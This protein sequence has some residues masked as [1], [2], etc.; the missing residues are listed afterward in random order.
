M[1]IG[2]IIW[3]LIGVLT[4]FDLILCSIYS[5]LRRRHDQQKTKLKNRISD[6]KEEAMKDKQLL[7]KFARRIDNWLYGLC[8]YTSIWVG[9]VPSYTFRR[10]IFRYVF[11]MQINRHAIIHGGCEIRSPWNIKIGNSVIGVGVILDGR[12][13]IEIEDDV[14]L[15]SGVWIWTEQHD[16]EDPYFRCLDK[17]GM[18]VIRKH[19]WIGN[20]VI[21]L[22]RVTIEEGDV[23]AAGAVV[24]KNC[25]PFT[26]YGGVPAKE[27][28]KRNQD[29]RYTD[30]TAGIWPF[31]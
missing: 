19:A 18:V 12:N 21:I 6:V 8:R 10:W 30:V 20:R 7:K 16:S 11:C 14:V 5:R 2:T 1:T 17:G 26:M 29:L 25:V 24:T 13:G 28:H 4:V 27:I 31:Y 3:I 22:P 9:K 15:A 23:I